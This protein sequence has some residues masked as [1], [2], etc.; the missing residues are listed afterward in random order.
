MPQDS[1]LY[2]VGRLRML[3]RKLLDHSQLERLI[4]A[5]DEQEALKALIEMGY[6]EGDQK[7]VEDRAA[8]K[9]LDAVVLLRKLSPEPDT[10]EAFMLRSDAH[11]LKTLL[12]SRML[13][14]EPEGLSAAG[15]LPLH[16]LRQA[17]TERQYARLPE[18]WQSTLQDLE[19]R[20]A[21]SPDPMQIDVWLDKAMYRQM[22]ALLKKS[23]SEAAKAW[24]KSRADF[25]NLRAFLRLKDM[26]ASLPLQDILVEGG[27]IE[28]EAFLSALEDPQPLLKRYAPYGESIL[29]LA[30]ESLADRQALSRLEPA[31]EGYLRGLFHEGRMEVD[32]MDVLI[33][34]LL[35]VEEEGAALRLIFAGK[36]N[37]L[38]ADAIKERLGG[39]HG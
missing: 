29:H 30:Q 37:R 5:N 7:D 26:D 18:P 20:L 24:L 3:R 34:Y 15:G 36:R 27:S 2:A 33:N 6:L 14:I 32:S 16:V 12:K 8:Q 35:S 17:V 28:H 11:N 4:A 21:L 9:A 25:V 23:S 39:I 13:D 10:T 22:K 1:L 19:Q 38:S 31:M